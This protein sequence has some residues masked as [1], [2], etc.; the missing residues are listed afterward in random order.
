[1]EAVPAT[2]PP[3][4]RSS[5]APASPQQAALPAHPYYQLSERKLGWM[6][7]RAECA[8]KGMELA[9][10]QTAQEKLALREF[11]GENRHFFYLIIRA[12]S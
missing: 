2:V 7:A 10:V 5:Y 8:M 12:I 1:M 11:M 6:G 3:S 9:S 4:V